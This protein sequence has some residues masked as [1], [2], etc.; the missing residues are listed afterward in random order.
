[1]RALGLY[2]RSHSV[3]RAREDEEEGVA[4]RVHLDPVG[5]ERLSDHPAVGGQHVAVPVAEA[6]EELRRSLDIGED[7]GDGSRGERGHA[8]IVR[9]HPDMRCSVPG[10]PCT[11][12]R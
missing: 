3:P 10:W 6:L 8:A 11:F 5:G 1:M 9:L 4:L 2:G 7:E 12:D